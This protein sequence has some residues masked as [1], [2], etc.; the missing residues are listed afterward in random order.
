[1]GMWAMGVVAGLVSLVGL[2]LASRAHDRM[3]EI[4]GLLVFLC[5]VLVIFALIRE[6]TRPERLRG[7]AEEGT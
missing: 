6:A 4:F 7:E 1:M 5:G 3:F 2:I